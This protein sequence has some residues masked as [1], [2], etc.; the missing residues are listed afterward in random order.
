MVKKY[1]GKANSLI[2][3]KNNKF[4]VPNFFVLE[5]K[6]YEYFLDS[7]NLKEKIKML[8]KSKNCTEARELILNSKMP[9]KLKQKIK[10]IWQFLNVD[11]VSVR[12]SAANED[13]KNKSFAGQYETILNVSYKDLYESIKRCWAS[14]YNEN[15]ILY[16]NNM[17]L[18]GMNVIIQEMIHPD[19]SGVAFS[20][21]VN[22][23]TE[24]YSIIEIGKG[25]GEKLVSGKI[26]PTKFIVR[27]ETLYPDLTKGDIKIDLNLLK[28]LESI[29][30]K[31]EKLYK[32]P[33]DIEYAIK[34][35]KIYILQA[36][37]ITANGIVPVPYTLSI[38]RP[39]SVIEEQLHFKGEFEGIKRLTRNLYYFK[40][41]FLHNKQE[42]NV[43]I[44]YNE[45]DLEEDPRMIYYYMD[46]D[47]EKIKK[48]YEK[49]K[50]NIHDLNNI[51]KMQLKIELND[52]VEKIISMYPFSSL[53]QLAGHFDTVSK[54][55]K[56]LLYDYRNNYEYVIHDAID[57]LM[58]EIK[59]N[60]PE[61]LQSMCNFITLE[62]YQTKEFPSINTLKERKK[63][64]IY[65]EGLHVTENY[66]AWLKEHNKYI[67]QG[68][69]NDR[70]GQT[71]YRGIAIGRVCKIFSE[72]DFSKFQKKIY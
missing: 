47:F 65:F 43:C 64:Y 42:K 37:P 15:V 48:E 41:L 18:F 58:K 27:R 57:Y 68:H 54:R 52:Y 22:S 28:Q 4:N 8:I 72:E 62:E 1:G 25:N 61:E 14:L 34:N 71:A 50:K 60:L 51:V 23:S 7:N 39:K 67:K 63:G 35:D 55:L 46:L 9:E 5:S 12:S 2:K 19:F 29:L 40:P 49:V 26:T 36:R 30:L 13:G 59:N 10:N 20:K 32:E 44:Y 69:T 17:D 56:E 53:G 66:D 21:D 24:N 33:V 70:K 3:L 31:I 16:S 38:T 45:F 6:E 11:F